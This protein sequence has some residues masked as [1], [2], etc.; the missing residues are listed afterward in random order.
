M[1]SHTID[2]DTDNRTTPRPA[3]AL[4]IPNTLA[5]LG[6]SGIIARMMP[7]AEIC[8]FGSFEAMENS[9][10]KMFFHYFITVPILLNHASFFIQRQHQTIVLVHG[11]DTRHLPQGFHKLNVL[12]SEQRLV[13]AFLQLANAAHNKRGVMPQ[14]VRQAQ[15]C[16]SND[17]L[18]TPRERDVLRELI[19]GKTN[20]EIANDLGIALAT[21]ISHRKN[22]ADKLGVKHLAALTIYAVTHGIVKAEDI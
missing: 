10:G 8:S 16:T 2:S 5:A 3:I 18:L 17:G 19:K 7:H 12:E 15:G 14:P 21:V 1:T 6:L 4:V 13:R 20:K 22:I 11:E 9:Q